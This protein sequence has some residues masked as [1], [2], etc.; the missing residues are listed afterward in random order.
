MINAGARGRREPMDI[1]VITLVLSTQTDGWR[2]IILQ[3]IWFP[4]VLE[5][6]KGTNWHDSCVPFSFSY[7]HLMTFSL[8][9][10]LSSGLL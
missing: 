10:V 6:F 3:N 7:G 1:R 4:N 2:G 8:E 9:Y 5:T